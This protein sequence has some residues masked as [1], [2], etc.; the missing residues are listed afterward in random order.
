[1]ERP[2]RPP[3]RGFPSLPTGVPLPAGPRALQK[4]DP[5]SVPTPA[6]CPP[7]TPPLC[8]PPARRRE[9]ARPLQTPSARMD[10]IKKGRADTG[11]NIPPLSFH[12]PSEKNEGEGHLLPSQRRSPAPLPL[13][14][15]DLGGSKPSAGG[16]GRWGRSPESALFCET[17]FRS[18]SASKGI[19]S[20]PSL[21]RL[22]EI[23][24][25]K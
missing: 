22:M 4:G 21:P 12:P 6:L 2:I 24:L 7:L 1:M 11:V 25:F 19:R 14:V 8:P 13:A 23:Q 17:A 3:P 9:E 5:R 16:G 10:E 18:V 20:P 15:G